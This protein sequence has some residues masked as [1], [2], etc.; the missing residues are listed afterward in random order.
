[1]KEIV[2][3]KI[4]RKFLILTLLLGCFVFVVSSEQMTQNVQAAPCC[5]SCPGAG[6]PIDFVFGCANGCFL[7]FPGNTPAQQQC[8][9]DCVLEGLQCYSN[10]VFCFSGS[11]PYEGCNFTSDCPIGWYCTSSGLCE[12]F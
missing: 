2:T 11:G 10:C 12:N 1:M 5:E 9:D 3:P 7:Q 6:D 4:L 8:T